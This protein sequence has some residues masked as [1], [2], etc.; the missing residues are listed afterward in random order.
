MTLPN[1]LEEVS[2]GLPRSFLRSCLLL[3]IAEKPSYGYDLQ[4]GLN[5][6]GMVNADPGGLYRT[7]RA[8]EH[9][10]LVASVWDSSEVGPPRRVY[11]LTEDGMDWL[12]AWAGAHAET[13]RILG[14]FLERY[15]DVDASKPL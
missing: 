7:L 14:S 12:H 13:R 4:E 6:L 2:G 10:G 5:A 3:L 9:D 11:S 15:A 8:M 1:P